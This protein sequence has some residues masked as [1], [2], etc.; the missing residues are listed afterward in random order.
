MVDARGRLRTFKKRNAPLL[1]WG[2]L[3]AELTDEGVGSL[4]T[5]A[6]SPHPPPS[7]GTFSL[8]EKG[9]TRFGLSKR[10]SLPTGEGSAAGLEKARLLRYTP[11]M[12]PSTALAEK[13]PEVRAILARYPV[14]NPRLFGSVARGEDHDGSDVDLLVE[15]RA[16]LTYFDLAKL[17]SELEACLG[18][19]VDV[20]LEAGL[21]PTT[22]QFVL[23]DARPL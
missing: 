9:I 3:S 11:P 21:K 5:K 7:G 6:R 19:T 4:T 8:W 1:P 16:G 23:A 17:K 22:R 20:G 18:V 14:A 10:G 13:L 2:K 12:K 15:D